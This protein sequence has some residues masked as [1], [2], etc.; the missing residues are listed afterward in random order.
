MLFSS[1][2]GGRSG[3]GVGSRSGRSSSGVGASGG[4][5][6]SG[7]SGVASGFR[8]GR[9]GVGSR[10][11]GGSGFTSGGVGGRGFFF[12]LAG[13]DRESGDGDRSDEQFADHVSQVLLEGVEDRKGNLRLREGDNAL[14]IRVARGDL[15]GS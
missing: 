11:S 8:G 3:S 9:G 4:G 1:G 10:V 13:G 6:T 7:G 5:V 2:V 14:L 12:L 15:T